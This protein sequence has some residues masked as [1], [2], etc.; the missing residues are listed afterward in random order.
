MKKN[1]SYAE[2]FHKLKDVYCLPSFAPDEL[3]TLSQPSYAPTLQAAGQFLQVKSIK[4][5]NISVS[6]ASES[7]IG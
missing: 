7:A 6:S 5:I 3:L 1:F 2:T 4:N